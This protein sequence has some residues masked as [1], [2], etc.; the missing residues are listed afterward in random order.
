MNVG[1]ALQGLLDKAP[2]K[3]IDTIQNPCS[4]HD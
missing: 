3:G 2:L 1:K 4:A